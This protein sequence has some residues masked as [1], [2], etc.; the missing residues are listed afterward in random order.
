MG[1][2]VTDPAIRECA[3]D[4][5]VRY[6]GRFFNCSWNSVLLGSGVVQLRIRGSVSPRSF[7]SQD[8]RDPKWEVA[9]DNLNLHS[10][11]ELQFPYVLKYYMMTVTSTHAFAILQYLPRVGR[12]CD[13]LVQVAR[14]T[15]MSWR[16][17][18][19]RLFGVLLE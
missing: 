13:T 16:P 10:A 17:S 19:W 7:H 9:C 5:Q 4:V 3:N 1:F 12:L 6:R 14:L 15:F 8:L 2:R 11:P 18:C